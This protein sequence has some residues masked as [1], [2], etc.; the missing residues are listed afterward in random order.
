V[1]VKWQ[2]IKSGIWKLCGTRAA[3]T[4]PSKVQALYQ[5]EVF[6]YLF[7][8]NDFAEGKRGGIWIRE[9]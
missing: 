8:F 3:E 5:L 2:K 6:R 1:H 4:P 7:V 9:D